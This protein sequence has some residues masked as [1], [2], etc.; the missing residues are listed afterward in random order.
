[1]SIQRPPRVDRD[2]AEQLLAGPGPV[3]SVLRVAAAPAHADELAGEEAAVA[4]FRAAE[5]DTPAARPSALRTV[6]ARVV[7]VKAGIVLAAAASTGIVLAA[8]GGVL[9]PWSTTPDSPPPVTTT[10][11]PATTTAPPVTTTPPPAPNTPDTGV[12]GGGRPRATPDPSIVGLCRAYAAHG[13][14]K[15]DNPA[16]RAL[17]EA[18]GGRK[19]VP[20]FCAEVDPKPVKPSPPGDDDHGDDER[21]PEISPPGPPGGPAPP[22]DDDPEQ[23]TKKKTPGSPALGAATAVPPSGA[24]PPSKGG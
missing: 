2:T 23:H 5:V 19:A 20:G 21:P 6:L 24:E 1:M 11:R 14:G 17:V 9:T 7:T 13:R 16:F 4:A 15:L 10:S 3:A 22:D 8:T 18:A 12:T